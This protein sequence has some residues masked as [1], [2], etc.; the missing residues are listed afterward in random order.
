MSYRTLITDSYPYEDSRII[1]FGVPLGKDA[2]K[3]LN[4]LRESSWFIEFFDVD[5]KKNLIEN[6]KF[7]DIGDIVL[8]SVD[9]IL[10]QTKSVLDDGKIPLILGKSHLLTYYA[11]KAFDDD[12]KLVSFDAH[13]DIKDRYM[14]EKIGESIEPFNLDDESRFNCTTWLRRFCENGKEKD[15]ALVGLRSCDADD[16][17]FI[18]RNNILHFTPS[19]IRKDFYS[20]QRAK[21]KLREFVKD[22]KVYISIDIDVF[23]PSIAPAVD[24][25][26]PNGL[27]L[28]EFLELIKEVCKGRIV[29]LDLV[30]I[31]L[32]EDKIMEITEFLAVKS[33]MEILS[34]I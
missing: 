19:Q 13:A 29:G 21:E 34:L 3:I 30:E 27:H 7:C 20:M 10:L 5:K 12:V 15:V 1:V 18:E 23:D 25:P 2:K 33:I 16:Y 31:A 26:E 22:S 8:T 4:S 6:A 17:E 24:H 14:D 32:T 9:D 28:P 11:L